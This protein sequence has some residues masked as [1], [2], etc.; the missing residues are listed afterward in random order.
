MALSRKNSSLIEV[1]GRK[2]RWTVAPDDMLMSIIVQDSTGRGPKLQ[3]GADY[4]DRRRP[5]GMHLEQRMKITPKIVCRVIECALRRGWNPAGPGKDMGFSMESEP[6]LRDLLPSIP[7]SEQDLIRELTQV[8]EDQEAAKGGTKLG[9]AQAAYKECLNLARVLKADGLR[10]PHCKVLSKEMRF[11]DV[12][13][14]QQAHFICRSC[15][16]SFRP[17]D[18]TRA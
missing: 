3:V 7:K 10:C 8:H 14:P 6:T 15:G 2:F 13:P 18:L 1:S 4:Y 5:D 9:E 17:E 11:I 12:P 16:R